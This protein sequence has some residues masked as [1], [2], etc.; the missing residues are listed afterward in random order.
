MAPFSICLRLVNVTLDEDPQ[1]LRDD[2][3][4]YD[5]RFVRDVVLFGSFFTSTAVDVTSP[6]LPLYNYPV[7]SV[8]DFRWTSLETYG[9]QLK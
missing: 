6:F 4:R 9:T 3:K 7:I 1:K 5:R 8:G 2:V